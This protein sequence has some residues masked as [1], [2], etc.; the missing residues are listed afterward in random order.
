MLY[1]ISLQVQLYL[2][3]CQKVVTIVTTLGNLGSCQQS[4]ILLFSD[5]HNF[6]ESLRWGSKNSNQACSLN[7][8]G[9]W[10]SYFLLVSWTIIWWLTTV[11][12][13]YNSSLQ[14]KIQNNKFKLLLSNYQHSQQ[15]QQEAIS[16]KEMVFR[17]WKGIQSLR[18]ARVL[19][20]SA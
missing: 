1:K 5:G 20:S 2:Q 10:P 11:T 6:T 4:F 14:N 16:Q 18:K 13:K 9:Y 15:K 7:L 19:I 3:H 12:A 17:F 8:A